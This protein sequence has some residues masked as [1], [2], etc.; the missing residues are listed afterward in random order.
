MMCWCFV[1]HMF[2]LSREFDQHFLKQIKL[3]TLQVQILFKLTLQKW[4]LFYCLLN[5]GTLNLN[6]RK[7]KFYKKKLKI[8]VCVCVCVMRVHV[9]KI[10]LMICSNMLIFR[11]TYQKKIKYLYICR[12]FHFNQHTRI[13]LELCEISKSCFHEIVW[14]RGGYI[15][16]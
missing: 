8:C 5:Y 14:Y 11:K 3:L 16:I 6:L 1:N 2:T 10:F 13:S 9:C 4:K 15:F 7:L 12:M